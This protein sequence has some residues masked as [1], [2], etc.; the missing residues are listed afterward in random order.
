[1]G[2]KIIII[3]MVDDDDGDDDGDGDDGDGALTRLGDEQ[4]D[5]RLLFNLGD[6]G[7]HRVNRHPSTDQSSREF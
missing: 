2:I 6:L 3:V 5:S 1:M 7:V 4:T